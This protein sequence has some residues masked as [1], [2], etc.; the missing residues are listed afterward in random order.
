VKAKMSRG[1]F[2]WSSLLLASS[3]LRSQM[4]PQPARLVVSSEPTGAIVTIKGNGDP[5]S[6]RTAA[7]FVVSPGQYAVSVATPD[8]SVRCPEV[9]HTLASGQTLIL[10]CSAKGW[11]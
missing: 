6:Q 3:V 5:V 10:T 4:P 2:F 9:V 11:Q 7:T 1:M 8:G